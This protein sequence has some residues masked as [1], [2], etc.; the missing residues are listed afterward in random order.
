MNTHIY[1]I[2]SELLFPQRAWYDKV[3][4]S[5]DELNQAA[6]KGLIIRDE[7]EQNMYRDI[8]TFTTLDGELI[9]CF[10]KDKT[11][12]F[13]TQSYGLTLQKAFYKINLPVS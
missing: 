8:Y 12:G 6:I 3:C 4:T 1:L 11:F 9:A 2:E 13:C 7:K 5:Q 10:S